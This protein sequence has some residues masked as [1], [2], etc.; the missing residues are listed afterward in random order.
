M[1]LPEERRIE[2]TIQFD[3]PFYGHPVRGQCYKTFYGRNLQFFL[4]KLA[5]LSLASLSTNIRLGWKSLPETNV[6]AYYEES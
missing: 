4:N 6:I 1:Q 5:C 2:T 3:F